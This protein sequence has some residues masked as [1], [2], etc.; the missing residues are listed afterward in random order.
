MVTRGGGHINAS[1][2]KASYIVLEQNLA[3]L[4]QNQ[5]LEKQYISKVLESLD[6]VLEVASPKVAIF[7]K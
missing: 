5:T 6:E 1:Y 2:T 7:S 3:T 4:C